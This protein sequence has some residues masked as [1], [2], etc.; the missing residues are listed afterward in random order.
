MFPFK[1]I[2]LVGVGGQGILTMS[3]VLG[4]AAISKGIKVLTAETHGMAQRG[5]S[6]NVHLRI[7]DVESPLIGFGMADAIVGLEMIE[8][9][10]YF[11]YTNPKTLLILNNRIIRPPGAEKFLSVGEVISELDRLGLK[12]VIIDAL[13]LALKAGSRISENIVLVGGLLATNVLSGYIDLNDV[14]NALKSIFSGSSLEIN[15]KAIKYGYEYVINN[16]GG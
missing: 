16:F 9:L 5:G 7:G 12:Y 3:R 1:N 2:L 14:E 13:K 8:V 10:R 11:N 4:I 15:I 6:V